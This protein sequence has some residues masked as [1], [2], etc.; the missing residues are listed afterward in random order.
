[1]A[2]T[3]IPTIITIYFVFI[4]LVFIVIFIVRSNMKKAQSTRKHRSAVKSYQTAGRKYVSGQ[5]STQMEL[6]MRLPYK[7]FKQLYPENKWTYKEYKRMQMQ[8]AFRRSYSS[9]DN[10]RMVR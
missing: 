7:R 4:I 1:M 2:L 5:F 3:F 10:K 9:Q 6:D 8:T